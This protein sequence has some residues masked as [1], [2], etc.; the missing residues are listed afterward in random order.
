MAFVSEAERK[1]VLIQKMGAG[2]LG[3]GEYFNEGAIHKQALEAIIPRK[4]APFNSNSERK[5]GEY[6]GGGEVTKGTVGVSSKNI[7][8]GPGSYKLKSNF[9]SVQYL[10]KL[11]KGGT[12]LSNKQGKLDQR[13]QPYAAG[14]TS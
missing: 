6:G 7:G 2:N 4:H 11:D 3:P 9:E 1:S 8:P 5:V 10:K 14:S 13:K 12:Y